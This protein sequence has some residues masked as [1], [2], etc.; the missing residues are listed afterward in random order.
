MSQIRENKHKQLTSH[1]VATMLMRTNLP[2]RMVMT[3]GLGICVAWRKEAA[4]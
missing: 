4:P 1:R 2:A 3:F